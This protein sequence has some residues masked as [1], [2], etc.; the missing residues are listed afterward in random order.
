MLNSI[1]SQYIK[2]DIY[3]HGPGASVTWTYI[4]TEIKGDS[5]LYYNIP[6]KAINKTLA[7]L[8]ILI[9]VSLYKLNKQNTDTNLLLFFPNKEPFFIGFSSG[10]RR[11]NYKLGCFFVVISLETSS[12]VDLDITKSLVEEHFDHFHW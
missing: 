2:G 5:H 6:I 11:K 1:K 3:I 4:L 10:L 7:L 9:I 12:P 8:Y